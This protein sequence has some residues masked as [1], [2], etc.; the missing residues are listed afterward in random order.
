M[1]APVVTAVAAV[2]AHRRAA[3]DAIAGLPAAVPLQ[4]DV[5][6]IVVVLLFL[7]LLLAVALSVV[8]AVRGVRG[9]RRTGDR[10]LLYLAVGIVLLSGAPVTLNLALST[11]TGAGEAT[12]TTAAN[13]TR[14]AGL[15][16][17]IRAIYRPGG[18]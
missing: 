14:L 12:V 18:R 11:A 3:G 7:S 8:V 9:Y 16:V 15:G 4:V 5:G 13:L 6:R 17:I 1:T 10:A 2:R